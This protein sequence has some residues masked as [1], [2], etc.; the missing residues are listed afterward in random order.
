MSEAGLTWHLD[1]WAEWMRDQRTDFGWGYSNEDGSGAKSGTSRSFDSMV[2]EA[3]MR[4]AQAV[5]AII[6]SLTPV[7]SA[8]IH[9]FHIGAVYRFARNTSNEIYQR[10]RGLVG[11]GLI[12]RGIDDPFENSKP[13]KPAARAGP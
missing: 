7:E 4:C 8:A 3:D 12:R 9:H 6:E 2:D 10:A 5:Q 11:A 1:N 13:G